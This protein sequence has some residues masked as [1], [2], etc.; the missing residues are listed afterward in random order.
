MS[1]GGVINFAEI[2]DERG[3]LIALEGQSEVPF[4]IKRAYYLFR[5]IDGVRRG[6]HAHKQLTQVAVCVSGS[7]KILLDDGDNKINILLDNPRSGLLISPMVWHE[8]YDF[9]SDCVLLVLA[10]DLYDESDYIRNYIDFKKLLERGQ[11]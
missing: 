2:S 7:C 1:I 3:A 10:D 8:M 9:S 6:F 4:D 11:C 5:T